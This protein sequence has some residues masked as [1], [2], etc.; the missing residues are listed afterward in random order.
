MISLN[1]SFVSN[2][3]QQVN[4]TLPGL[5]FGQ[6]VSAAARG[7]GLDASG[8]ISR[9]P[10]PGKLVYQPV[11]RGEARLAWD[12]EIY[13]LDAQN[14]WRIRIDALT[15]DVLDKTNYVVHENSMEVYPEPVESPN[16]GNRQLLNFT[17]LSPWVDGTMHQRQ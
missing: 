8:P 12:L 14:W 9:N 13:E 10:I 17:D 15:G 5:N 3:Q 16:H 11:N 4:T 1:N 6:A 2:I 7:L